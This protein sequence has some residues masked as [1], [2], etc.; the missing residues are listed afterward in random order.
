MRKMFVVTLKQS[1]D[2]DRIFIKA[3]NVTKVNLLTIDIDGS[4]VSFPDA[5]GV[6]KIKKAKKNTANSGLV[7]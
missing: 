6:L 1:K 7:R 3:K 5:L 4:T 2:T